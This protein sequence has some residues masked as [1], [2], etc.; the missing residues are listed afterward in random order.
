MWL[1]QCMVLGTNLSYQPSEDLLPGLDTISAQ[2][3]HNQVTHAE[4]RLGQTVQEL[5]ATWTVKTR[6]IGSVI[7]LTDLRCYF[8]VTLAK[9]VD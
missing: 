5:Q 7:F 8:A 3:N 2:N 6:K 4:H 1:T 9:V